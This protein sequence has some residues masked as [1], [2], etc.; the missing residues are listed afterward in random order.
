MRKH[1]LINT[2]WLREA[3]PRHFLCLGMILLQ[4]LQQNDDDASAQH[5]V[6]L[7][8]TGEDLASVVSVL[9]KT[10]DAKDSEKDVAR[11]V[12]QDIVR[13][14]G[15]VQLILSIKKRGHRGYRK[16]RIED[17]QSR[18]QALPE[19]CVPPEII[20]LLPLDK[21]LDNIQIQKSA[22]PVATPQNE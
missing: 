22:T 13:R 1:T 15:V 8:R 5:R 4:Q 17:F 7:P 11:L 14:D 12:H 10:S 18:A 21:L 16:V 3:M 20:K 9:L 2:E 19:H 6:V